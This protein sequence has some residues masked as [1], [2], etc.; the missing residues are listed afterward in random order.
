MIKKNFPANRAVSLKDTELNTYLKDNAGRQ[1]EELIHWL[2]IPSVSTQSEHRGDM[3]RAAHWLA[4]HLEEIGLENVEV[5]ESDGHPLVY[6]EWLHVGDSC[7]TVLI[8]GHYDVQPVDPLDKWITP[9]FEPSIRG[10]DLFARGTT[11]DKGQ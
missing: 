2:R 1:I 5:K 3:D 10:D 9:P 8:Y 11:D 6:G 7:P 4:N